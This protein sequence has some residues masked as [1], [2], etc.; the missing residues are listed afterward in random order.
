M[1]DVNDLRQYLIDVW[2]GVEQDIMTMTLTS[3][4][5]VSIPAVAPEKDILNIY[6]DTN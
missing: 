4:A 5:D 1:Q 2:A 6:G 3:D